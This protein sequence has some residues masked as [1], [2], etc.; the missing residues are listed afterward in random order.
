MKKTL[1]C[2]AVLVMMLAA[3]SCGSNIPDKAADNVSAAYSAPTAPPKYP[4]TSESGS[5]VIDAESYLGTW[6]CDRCTITISPDGNDYIADIEWSHSPGATLKH[7]IWKYKCV[8]NESDTA[9]ICS[10]GICKETEDTEDGSHT[11]TVLYEDGTAVL[12]INV[13]THEWQGKELHE[14]VLVWQDDKENIAENMDFY[15]E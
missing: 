12:K 10:D 6:V 9:M 3:V 7:N 13:M 2:L 4:V 14:N 11:E 8:Y 15:K 1:S 5:V